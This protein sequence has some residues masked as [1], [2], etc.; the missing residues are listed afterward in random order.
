MRYFLEELLLE[1]EKGEQGIEYDGSGTKPSNRYA[2]PCLLYL[3]RYYCLRAEQSYELLND[4]IEPGKPNPEIFHAL[5]RHEDEK[6]VLRFRDL[7]AT[8]RGPDR[9]EEPLTTLVKYGYSDLLAKIC[10]NRLEFDS[11]FQ[12]AVKESDGM[13][14][15]SYMIISPL[16]HTA[17]QRVLPNLEVIKVLVERKGF[18]VNAT[19]DANLYAR[20]A[21]GETALHLLAPSR[22][23]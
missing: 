7:V 19:D 17:C 10:P 1:I 16:L 23:W 4:L 18:D 15:V 21:K 2:S 14:H 3:E 12:T 9:A 22:H 5:L 6:G 8:L 20:R 11:Q 13:M